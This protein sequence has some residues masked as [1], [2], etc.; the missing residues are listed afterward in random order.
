MCGLKRRSA[1]LRLTAVKC[2]SGTPKIRD[3]VPVI[4]T[5]SLEDRIAAIGAGGEYREP[6]KNAIAQFYWYYAIKPTRTSCAICFLQA[7]PSG[8]RDYPQ[9]RAFASLTRWYAQRA[10]HDPVAL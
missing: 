7:F 2:V 6:L 10:T 8:I 5:P 9:P 3:G 1:P 4:A